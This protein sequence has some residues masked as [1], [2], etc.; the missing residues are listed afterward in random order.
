LED[1]VSE[2]IQLR[3]EQP[4]T[5]SNTIS[6]L[7]LIQ[8]A[9][10]S[11]VSKENVEV[12]KELVAMH[13][14]EQAR[15][16]KVT[17]NRAFFALRKEIA[18]LDFYADKCATTDSGKVAY[19][20][21]SEKEISQTLDP[22]LFRHGFAMMFGQR[23]DGER[24]VASITLV[25][26][27]GHE[28]TR[29][30]AVRSGSTNRMKDATAADTGATTSAWRHLCIKLFGLKSRIREDADVANEGDPHAFVTAEQALELERRVKESDSIVEAFLKFCGAES[31]AKIPAR[32]YPDADQMLARKERKGR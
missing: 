11:G 5:I 26:E 14:E 32:K 2:E 19:R 27:D 15:Q 3:P 31:F 25:H 28:E 8:A 6:P 1:R 4:V 29:E 18:A 7:A 12:V 22:V 16:N 20:Y 17:F 23:Q 24:S 10:S 9:I 30:Y 21:C 13:R